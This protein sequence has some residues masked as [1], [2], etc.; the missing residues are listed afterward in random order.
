M[1]IY[2]RSSIKIYLIFMLIKYFKEYM[3]F[4]SINR[5]VKYDNI[6]K[7]LKYNYKTIFPY[8]IVSVL[9]IVI[10]AM[11]WIKNNYFA[12]IFYKKITLSLSTKSITPILSIIVYIS[13]LHFV[14]TMLP[15]LL[16]YFEMPLL[17]VF[18]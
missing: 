16:I 8:I 17:K 9:Y 3:W 7:L 15:L 4:M 5:F 10:L 18:L 13:F 12:N 1:L 2:I 6:I 14:I 11:F